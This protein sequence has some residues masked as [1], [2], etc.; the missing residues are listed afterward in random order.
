MATNINEVLREI[1]G[2]LNL[3]QEAKK[4]TTKK[5]VSA[6]VSKDPVVAGQKPRNISEK[7]HKLFRQMCQ[8]HE[9]KIEQIEKLKAE[10][11]SIKDRVGRFC[12]RYGVG[13]REDDKAFYSHPYKA[14]IIITRAPGSINREPLEKWAKKNNR[15]DLFAHEQEAKLDVNRLK[16]LI[17]L[18]VADENLKET[19]QSNLEALLK[20]ARTQEGIL[21]ETS[22][23]YLDLEKYD[24]LK[25]TGLIP[26]KIV[27]AAELDMQTSTKI[28]IHT[29]SDKK[30]RCPGCSVKIPKK[31]HLK[32]VCKRCGTE[33]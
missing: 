14:Q 17:R 24:E 5:G 19:L 6:G 12:L 20:L 31:R 4:S 22:E 23:S 16:D 29:I 33:S 3:H 2:D 27:Q 18:Q 8:N 15:P 9:K 11:G 21:E 1:Q 32:H 10:V 28:Q 26:E 13:V 25:S 7:N 30:D